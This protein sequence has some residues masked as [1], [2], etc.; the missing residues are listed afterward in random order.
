MKWWEYIGN[1]GL[2]VVGVTALVIYFKKVM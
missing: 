2:L 1:G